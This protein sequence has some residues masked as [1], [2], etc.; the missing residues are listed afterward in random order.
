MPIDIAIDLGTYKTVI[1]NGNKILLEQPTVATVDSETW[2]PLCFGDQAKDMIGRTSENTETVLPI[3][4][5]II[6]DYDIAEQMLSNYMGK[7]LGKRLIRPRVVVAMPSGATSIQRRSVANAV[8]N[9]GGR[10]V[11][12][13]DTAV[14]AAIGLGIDFSQAGGKMVVDIGAGVTDI[15]TLSAGGIVQC[16]SAPVGSGDFDEAIIRYIKKE[17]NVLI[18]SLSAESIKKQIGSVVPRKEEVTIKAKGRNLFSGLPVY[19]DV[20]SVDV[21]NAM[22]DTAEAICSAIKGVIE[23]TDPDVI[24]DVISDKIYVTGAGA[25]INGMEELLSN[26]LSGR[27]KIDRDGAHTVAYGAAMAARNSNLLR[28]TDYQLRSIEDLIV[29]D[30][31]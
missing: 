13:I 23:R 22:A 26:Y 12:I 4:H 20:S 10:S 15:A 14:A 27:V 30:P 9:A 2:E 29:E 7:S 19:F 1:V 11:R 8:E 3:Q 31:V 16:E 18:G 28:D 24:A 5:G 21:Y 6:A 25:C 17:H